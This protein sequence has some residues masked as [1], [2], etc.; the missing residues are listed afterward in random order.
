MDIKTNS[1]LR[2][3][4]FTAS[5]FSPL[6]ERIITKCPNELRLRTLSLVAEQKEP[7]VKQSDDSELDSSPSRHH[8][9]WFPHEKSQI[10]LLIKWS[11]SEGRC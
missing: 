1:R 11:G 10:V 9:P 5:L 4:L 8:S 3:Q 7:P 6:E 2:V